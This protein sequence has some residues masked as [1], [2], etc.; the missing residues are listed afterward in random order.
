METNGGNMAR[1][2]KKEELTLEEKLER[3]LVPVEEQLYEVPENWCWTYLKNIA[4]W[5]AGGTPSR[6]NLAFY[7]G[8]I[9]WVKTGELEDD[10][11]Y[12]TK[13]K[14]SEEAI[15]KSSAKLF[16]VGS[17]LIAMYGAT[18]GKT[19]ILRVEAATNQACA[20]AVCNDSL[21]NKYL[22][23]YLQFQKNIFIKQG[24]GGAQ[25]NISQDIIKKNC[26]PLPPKVEQQRIVER[27][28]SLFAKL[29]EAK[30]KVQEVIDGYAIREASLLQKAISGELTKEWRE[31]NGTSKINWKTIS[32]RDCGTW[33]GGGTPTTSKKEYWNGGTIPWITSKDMKDR[34]IVD[35][36][37]HITQAG[38]NNSSARYCDKPAVLFVMR[39]GILRRILPVCMVKVPFTVNQDLKAVIPEKIQQKYLYWACTAYEKDIRENCMKSGTTVESIEAKKLLEYKLPLP[40]EREQVVIVDAIEDLMQKE[41]SAKRWALQILERIEIMKKS[42]LAKAF[43]GELGTNNSDEESSIELLKQI[44]EEEGI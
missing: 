11:L 3:A 5:G 27:I 7:D 4:Q 25:P 30:E 24:K 1:G 22:F 34:L 36:L 23:Y 44:L 43:R 21:Y 13:E 6:K 41:E 16:P 20:C 37:L 2:K 28:E 17:V 18:I 38:V 39:S 12:N 32:L 31:K 26:I 8:N 29:D 14:I 15:Q 35:S 19:A 40:C 33:F 42:I 9:P 10:Y